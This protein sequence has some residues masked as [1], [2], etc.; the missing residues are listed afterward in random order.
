M[1][2]M[3][4]E[5]VCYL[6]SFGFEMGNISASKAN[7]WHERSAALFFN[8]RPYRYIKYIMV[9]NLKVPCHAFPVITRPLVCYVA[10]SACKRSAKSQALKVHPVASKT[11]KIPVYAAPERLVLYFFFLSIVTWPY[12][13][14]NGPIR[15]APHTHTHP[16]LFS[17]WTQPETARHGETQPELSLSTHTN[18]L[19]CLADP[20]QQPGND[21][22]NPAHTVRSS[23]LKGRTLM[24]SCNGGGLIRTE[25]TSWPISAQWAHRGGQELQQ[26]V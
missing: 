8:Q 16:Y 25:W 2:N 26:G 18:S 7:T 24:F 10:F 17:A 5:E 19:S 22:S 13:G 1:W 23:S 9:I 15:G 21:T 3:F 14:P 20:T 12:P 4:V 11:Q 6:L